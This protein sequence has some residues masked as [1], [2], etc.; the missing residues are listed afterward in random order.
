MKQHANVKIVAEEN[1]PS[2]KNQKKTWHIPFKP[3]KI[4]SHS[5]RTRNSICLSKTLRS[6]SLYRKKPTESC[7]TVM[8]AEKNE[9]A[10]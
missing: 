8:N 3:K 4:H 10:K 1:L 9:F 2:G 5:K 6:L 7:K